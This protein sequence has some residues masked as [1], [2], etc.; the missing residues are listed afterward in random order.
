MQITETQS[1]GLK[2]EYRVV[3]PSGEFA[4]RLAT[5]LDKLGREA[6]LPGF[7][8]GKVP[9]TLLK[10]RYGDAIRSE[11]LEETLNESVS[12]TVAD[13]GLK[14]A[15]Q[16]QVKDVGK[17]EDGKDIE[18]TLVFENLPDVE[19]MD[20]RVL[21]LERLKVT[22]PD[23]EVETAL[24][25]FAEGNA[26]IKDAVPG[27]KAA[28]GDVL[29]IDFVGTVGGATF[30]GGTASGHHLRL[31]SGSFIP[32]FE[33]QLLG[34]AAGD[35]REVAVSFPATYGAAD[36]AGKDAVFHVV[37][38]EV[39]PTEPAKLDD[40]LAEKAGLKTLAELKDAIRKQ[41]ERDFGQI[42]RMRLKR[43]LLDRLSEAHGF[44][45]PEGMVEAE[46]QGIWQQVEAQR[47]AGQVDDSDKG[48]SEDELKAEYRKIADRRVRLG[49]LLA[50]V[51]K[52]AKI[53]VA[54]EELNQALMR[55]AQRYPGQERKVF[56]FYQKNPEAIA[57]L[58]APIYEDKVVD[59][60]VALAKI[61]E[62]PIT[63]KDLAVLD[64]E[65]EPPTKA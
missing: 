49:L 37:V 53:E 45:V 15:L 33:D 19:P 64:A 59:Y 27:R 39:K 43:Q 18:F 13:K 52:R 26:E 60:I 51:G 56:E 54:R 57:N 50:E 61:Q 32:G 10:Q 44:P 4:Q 22:V 11:A 9:P 24:G 17:Y 55:E 34:A 41:I 2:R 28:K 16:P 30:P 1:S 58:R 8:P 5:K 38:H 36:L 31:G 3:V 42:A 21:Q 48:K 29:V 62:K 46:F 63:P 47:K 35:K 20:F 65:P 6:R 40:A 23:D 7:R 25:R 12:K 14:P